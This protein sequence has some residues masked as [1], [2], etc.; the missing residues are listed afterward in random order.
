MARINAARTLDHVPPNHVPASSDLQA[1]QRVVE[2][3]KVGSREIVEE[4]YPVSK[5][6]QRSA[7]DHAA[8]TIG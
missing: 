6:V 5:S 8:R 3:H 2:E 4:E 7:D 1:P